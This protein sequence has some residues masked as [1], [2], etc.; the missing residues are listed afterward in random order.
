MLNNLPLSL[1]IHIPWC[2]EKCPYC[3]FNSHKKNNNL[4]EKNYINHLLND[5]YYDYDGRT[6]QTIFIGGGTPSLFSAESIAYL[7]K[8]LKNRAKIAKNCE[9]TLESNPNSAD[10]V[11]FADYLIAGV[12]RLSIGVQSFNPDQLKKLGRAHNQQ[13]AEM[14]VKSAKMAGFS[15]IN[16]DL[17]F[18]LP[19]QSVKEALDDL[20][21]AIDLNVEHI[22]WYQLTIEPNTSFFKNPPKLPN[23]DKQNEIYQAGINLLKK[24][25]F[26]Q[27]ELSAW[28]KNQPCLHNLNYWQF[29]DYL[30][31]GAGAHSKITQNNQIIRK[32]KFR[33][34][35]KYQNCQSSNNL[36]QN[37]YVDQKNILQNKD[38]PFEFLMNAWRLKEGVSSEL[39]ADRTGLSL[40]SIEQK[41]NKLAKQELIKPNF[42]QQLITTD[43]GFALL[44]NLLLEFL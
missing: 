43:K 35:T 9:I 1:Y 12:N 29:G 36:K 16:I 20:K 7:L 30:G 17:M 11:K 24:N 44:N 32:S 8:E 2:V 13:E 23:E 5:F 18:A 4:N 25:G 14:A 3:D 33:S 10:Y 41:L 21:N 6:I 34:P 31:I 37:P 19:N 40:N 26:Y 38:L 15:R 39:F 42:H 28:S 27:Y 22:S